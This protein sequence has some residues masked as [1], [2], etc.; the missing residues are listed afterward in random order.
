MWRGN[1]ER[2]LQTC[3][4]RLRE[5][6]QTIWA[7]IVAERCYGCH[8]S[9]GVAQKFGARLVFR[10]QI[11]ADSL[12]TNFQNL[13]SMALDPSDVLLKKPTLQVSHYGG[14]VL[15]IDSPEYVELREFVEDSR[16]GDAVDNCP[17]IENQEILQNSQAYSL[18]GVLRKAAVK[19]ANRL[20]HQAEIEQLEKNGASGLDSVLDALLSEP[21][22]YDNLMETYNEL[23]GTDSFLENLEA[24]YALRPENV[25]PWYEPRE[26]WPK[27]EDYYRAQRDSNE[28]LA[29]SSLHLIRYVVEGNRSFKEILNAPYRVVNALAACTLNIQDQVKFSYPVNC[30]P[31]EGHT[32]KADEWR[33]YVPGDHHAGVLT[34]PIFMRRHPTTSTNRNRHRANAITTSFLGMNILNFSKS[35]LLPSA[36]SEK[37]PTMTNRACTVCHAVMDPIAGS[38]QNWNEYG[39]YQNPSWYKD[40]FAPGFAGDAM[41]ADQTTDAVRWLSTRIQDDPR[42]AMQTVRTMAHMILG[43]ESVEVP[44]SVDKD[45]PHQM[46][47]YLNQEQ[48]FKKWSEAFVASG[49]N[50]KALI[51]TIVKDPIFA[52]SNPGNDANDLE[53]LLSSHYLPAKI[54]SPQKLDRKILQLLGR[55]WTNNNGESLLKGEFYH[56]YG[57]VDS[58]SVMKSPPDFSGLMS[59]VSL[60][61][62]S[63]MSCRVVPHLLSQDESVQLLEAKARLLPLASAM[64]EPHED[65]DRM[66]L[67]LQKLRFQLLGE[68]VSLDSAEV[69][70]DW[71]LFQTVMNEVKG[72]PKKQILNGNCQVK[73]RW[74]AQPLPSEKHLTHDPKGIVQAWS[75]VFAVMLADQKFLT[76]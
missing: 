23:L 50:L 67:S 3:S 73:V 63:E 64:D 12:N 16:S 55:G 69:S 2:R 27:Q 39:G 43:V 52:L 42:F 57:G 35:R 75:A 45:A 7:P 34:D 14:E 38:I 51:K 20:P 60:R 40:M 26:A 36:A 70:A 5:F 54:L 4:G 65:L 21:A 41:P 28:A 30:R 31:D 32:Y 61:M 71:E 29:R 74:D 17:I 46:E 48:S 72:D 62:A 18:Q 47:L 13:R 37:Q 49:Y 33:E 56:F 25:E 44:R 58:K 76:E 22:F 11:E 10:N 15:A 1:A 24:L 8:Q 9:G 66:K 68:E 53:R 19:L 6:G 59:Q